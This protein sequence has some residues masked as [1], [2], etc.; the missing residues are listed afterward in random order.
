MVSN[1]T[2][3]FEILANTA[4]RKFIQGKYCMNLLPEEILWREPQNLDV[5]LS[6]R[7]CVVRPCVAIC[8]D[9]FVDSGICNIALKEAFRALKDAKMKCPPRY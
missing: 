7:P 1:V 4:I 2:E 6:V 9:N 5:R 8:L 3:T